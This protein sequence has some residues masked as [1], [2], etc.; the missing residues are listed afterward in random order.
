MKAECQCIKDCPI[1]SD[2]RRKV[3]SNHN[4][5][6]DSDCVLY[7]MRCLCTDGDRRCHDDK[8]KHVHVEYYGTCKEIPKCSEDDMSDF[9]ERMRQWLFN[10]MKELR[11]R[12]KLNEPYLEMEEKAEQDASLRWSYA[13]IWKWC[14]LDSHPNDRRVSRHELF[15]LRAPLMAMEHCIAPFFDSCD[16]DNNHSID[17]KEWGSCLGV[18]T[19]EIDGHCANLA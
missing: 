15:P 5:T 2:P 9:R 1:E 14:D 8:Y 17:L 4:E 19:E 13:A 10:V 12:Q 6:W 7:Q 11:G 18:S 16:S 3:C